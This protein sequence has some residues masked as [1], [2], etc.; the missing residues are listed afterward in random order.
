MLRRLRARVTF[1]NVVSLAALFVALSTGGAYAVATITGAEVVDNSLTGAD[2]Q[3]KSGSAS[4]PAQNGSLTGVDIAGQAA[5]P[6]NGT[7]FID[8]SLS[9]AD[10][11]NDSLT[12]DD[13]LEA[14]LGLVPRADKANSVIK[15]AVGS[16][17][18]ANG[19]VTPDKLATAPAASVLALNGETTHTAAGT[20]LH[21]DYEI[22]D[23][24]NLHDTSSNT[25]NLVAPVS[26]TYVVSATVDWDPASTGYRRST[27]VGAGGGAVASVAGPP[28]PTP[29][30]TSQ[31]ASG[32]ERLAAGQ[33]VHVEVLQ[34][35]GS[36][37]NARISRFE[38]TLTGGY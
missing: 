33:A 15:G 21:A 17:Q 16:P 29:A 24:A 9:G 13:V 5:N 38:M 8:G 34:G 35:T 18:L 11:N 37:L 20:I 30:Y 10:V 1:A 7:P 12:G 25:E 32:V 6:V 23:T 26:G 28:L 22:F 2:V 14:S 36:D 27:I 3:G 19:A 4:T 31:N